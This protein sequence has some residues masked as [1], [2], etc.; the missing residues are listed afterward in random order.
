[1]ASVA[2]R[3]WDLKTGSCKDTMRGHTDSVSSVVISLDG[4][5][6]VSGSHDNT[7]R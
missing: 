6:L 5:T 7:I 2:C 3:V 4:S 1:M